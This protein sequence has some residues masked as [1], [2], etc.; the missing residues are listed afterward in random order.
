MGSIS[1]VVKEYS[2][3]IVYPFVALISLFYQPTRYHNV[4]T[5]KGTIIMVF[6]WFTPNVS[7]YKWV[8][9]LEGK[10]YRTYLLNLPLLF[11]DFHK[12]AERLN[13]FV[14]EYKLKKYTLVGISTGAVVC[15]YFLHTFKK[16]N[17]IHKFINIGGPMHGTPTARLISFAGKGRDILP[18]SMFIRKLQKK[19]IP[20]K[21]MVTITAAYDELV[22]LN[23][24]YMKGDRHY[25][26]PVWGHNRLHFSCRKTYELI[27]KIAER[28]NR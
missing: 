11:E 9:Y 12:S 2:Y 23:Y 21:K 4:T 15:L 27:A 5:S 18:G 7:H 24:S 25:T 26:I 8:F 14:T 1:N 6:C 28:Y 13:K 10:G 3:G 17:E 19:A 16:W 20:P 22:P